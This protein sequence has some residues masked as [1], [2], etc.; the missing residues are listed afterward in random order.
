MEL[1]IE[2]LDVRTRAAKRQR[3]C[4][5]L[6]IFPLRVINSNHRFQKVKAL[7]LLASA[8]H[9]IFSIQTWQL[10]SRCCDRF[11]DCP[12]GSFLLSRVR[13]LSGATMLAFALAFISDYSVIRHGF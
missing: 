7:V 12:D 9:G 11:G 5:C 4:F 8:N 2:N 3:A 6:P 10:F 1:P 13:V